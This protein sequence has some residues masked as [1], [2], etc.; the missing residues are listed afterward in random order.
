MALDLNAIRKKL[1]NLQTQTGKQ[2]NLW[3]PEPGKQTIR[4]VPYQYNK[5]NPLSLCNGCKKASENIG[6][7]IIITYS[8][9]NLFLLKTSFLFRVNISS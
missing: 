8:I 1:N 7:N 3:K 6:I 9:Y 2:N 5:D 4:I